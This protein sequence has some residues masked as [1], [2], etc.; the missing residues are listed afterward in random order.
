MT[1]DKRDR[2]EIDHFNYLQNQHKE[3]IDA[4][5]NINKLRDVINKFDDSCVH[6]VELEYDIAEGDPTYTKCGVVIHNG[7][8]WCGFFVSTEQLPQVTC[9]DCISL[10]EY[11]LKLLSSTNI[12]NSFR[13]KSVKYTN[14]GKIDASFGKDN[15][16]K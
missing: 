15:R 7:I 10:P 9:E 12:D 13:L 1:D 16:G 8:F 11:N 6:W 4:V 3:A 5:D 14:I 2:K